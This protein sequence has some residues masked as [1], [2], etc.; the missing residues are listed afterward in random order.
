MPVRLD[1]ARNET[2]ASGLAIDYCPVD[3]LIP[4]ARNARTHSEDQVAL[5]AG[6]IREFGFVNPVLVDGQNGIIAGH[7]RVLAARKLGMTTVPVIELGHL[8]AAQKR[9]YV[10]AD[11]RLAEAA[12]WDRELLALEV[13]DLDALGVDLGTL[14]FE[15][16]EIDALLR[17]GVPDP[18]EEATPEPP[19]VPVSRQ[20]DLWVLGDHRLLC[21]SATEAGDVARLLGGLRPHLMVT[22]PPYGVAY[23]PAWRNAAGLSATKRT[24]KVMNDDRADWR[25]A[26]ALFPGEVAYVWHGALHAAA[27][28]ASLEASGFAVRSQIIWAKERLVLSR[29]D[30]HW[31]HEPCWYAVR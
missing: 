4:Y 20:G 27:V 5:I 7:G 24:G 13:A 9:A 28:A 2:A 17:N 1:A 15:A 23:D 31:Q 8:S 12:G 16:G 14:G 10:L 25:E 26:W 11:N 30:Y 18:R 19:A 6:S 29:G 22:D 21:G 3:A